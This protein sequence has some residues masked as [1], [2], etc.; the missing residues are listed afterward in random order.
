MVEAQ[1]FVQGCT[2]TRSLL[3][4]NTVVQFQF[5]GQAALKSNN[6]FSNLRGLWMLMLEISKATG[7]EQQQLKIAGQHHRVTQ[8]VALAAWLGI[9]S[10]DD[11]WQYFTSPREKY[12]SSR[13]FLFLN[14][15]GAQRGGSFPS[16]EPKH[17]KATCPC[18]IIFEESWVVTRSGAMNLKV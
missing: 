11:G 13:W 3:L 2:R 8:T 9:S 17:S 16:S 18:S 1:N 5:V 14:L 6:L 7:D 12:S 10:I 4:L 15:R